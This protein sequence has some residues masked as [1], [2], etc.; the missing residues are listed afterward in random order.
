MSP[1]EWF[2][3]RDIPLVW[4]C[5]LMSAWLALV[6]WAILKTEDDVVKTL[7]SVLRE[8]YATLAIGKTQDDS[9]VAMTVLV[10]INAYG[11]SLVVDGTIFVVNGN[12]A[13]CSQPPAEKP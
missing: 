11:V 7:E 10:N 1:R 8:Q 6:V 13:V 4:L 12:V 2:V 3:A 5:C 9:P